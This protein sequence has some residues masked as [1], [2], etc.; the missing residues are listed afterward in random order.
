MMRA[1]CRIRR[2]NKRSRVRLRGVLVVIL[3]GKGMKR[4]ER[5]NKP[6]FQPP[7]KVP[8]PEYADPLFSRFISPPIN[9]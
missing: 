1:E 5:R 8:Y 2:R 6:M 3:V 9:C 4:K 7:L